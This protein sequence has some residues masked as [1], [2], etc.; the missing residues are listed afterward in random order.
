MNVSPSF[1][2]G[3][4][5]AL[6]SEELFEWLP[7]EAT[8]QRLALAALAMP[9]PWLWASATTARLR[10]VLRAGRTPWPMLAAALRLQ[11]L[12]VPVAYLVLIGVGGLGEIALRLS[13]DSYAVRFAILIGPLL[14]LELSLRAAERKAVAHLEALHLEPPGNLGQV[15]PGM[16][17]LVVVAVL[18][19]G[20]VMD[21][22]SLDRRLEVLFHGTAIGATVGMIA[23]VIGIGA[24]LPILFRVV[25]PTSRALPEQVAGEVWSTASRLGFS[26]RSVLSMQTGHR[27]VNAALVGPLPWPRYLVLTDGILG[28]LDSLSLRGV[29]AHE[30]GH[31]RAGHPGLLLIVFAILPILLIHPVTLLEIESARPVLLLSLGAA[32]AL[33][34]FVALRALMHRFEF[35]ADQLSA[36]ALGGAHPCITALRRVGDLFPSH[37]G[38]PSFRHPSEEQRVRNLVLWDTDPSFREAFLRRGRAVRRAIFAALLVALS[39]SAWSHATTAPIDVAVVRLYTGDF[40]GAAAALQGVEDDS[41]RVAQLREEI[42][43]ARELVPG[44]GPWSEIRDELANR[45]WQS[46][47]RVAR[48][49]GPADARA[50][51][52]L[53]TVGTGTDVVR[54]TAWMWAEAAAA[55]EEE[56]A[57]WVGGYLAGLPD[58]PPE[59]TSIVSGSR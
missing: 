29:V 15:F 54:E 44:G 28:Y 43:A 11:P 46:A 9:L 19:F 40:D 37:R 57:K 5:V 23:L 25:L 31:A 52:A 34:A 10:Q 48:E 2:L 45:A 47:I 53:A 14:L 39:L 51:F 26:P 8:A 21:T 38:R 24:L 1:L 3:L 16:T 36:D 27:L 33:G 56:R 58:T 13:P 42:E 6:L 12:T 49:R 59:L 17:L 18:T 22:I 35:E 32:A 4:A 55:G 50:L 41:D 20:V 30:V 7:G